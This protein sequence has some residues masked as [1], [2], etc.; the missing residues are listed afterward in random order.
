MWVVWLVRGAPAALVAGLIKTGVMQGREQGQRT[1]LDV[2][3]LRPA[4]WWSF[5]D[6]VRVSSLI[7]LQ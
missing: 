4:E 1:W 6:T 3:G 7:M 2:E 5:L